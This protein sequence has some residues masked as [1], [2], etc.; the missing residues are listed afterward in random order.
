MR[1]A[2]VVIAGGGFAALEAALALK[3]LGQER[4]ELTL[5]IMGAQGLGWAGDDYSKDELSAVRGWLMGKAGTIAGG[6]FEVQNNIITKRILGL[7]ELTGK[8]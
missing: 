2:R 5:E 4:A 8:G 1:P 7:P 6:S 3:A